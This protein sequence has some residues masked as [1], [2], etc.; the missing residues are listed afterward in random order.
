VTTWQ[1][2]VVRH[3]PGGL[4]NG[5]VVIPPLNL[6]LDNFQRTWRVTGILVYNKEDRDVNA[7]MFAGNLSI[8][9]F[10]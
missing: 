10:I 9:Y 2:Q 5:Y 4:G 6:H 7:E 3:I 8:K 1:I